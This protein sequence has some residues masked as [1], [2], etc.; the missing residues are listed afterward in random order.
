MLH[1]EMFQKETW[2]IFIVLSEVGES[3]AGL[4][5]LG[6]REAWVERTAYTVSGVGVPLSLPHWFG[7]SRSEGSQQQA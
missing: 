7:A 2:G 5:L 4:R 6:A 3:Q 1:S